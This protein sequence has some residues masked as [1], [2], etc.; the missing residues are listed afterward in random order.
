MKPCGRATSIAL[1]TIGLPFSSKDDNKHT[2][3]A[4]YIIVFRNLNQIQ[5]EELDIS[6][7]QLF[8]NLNIRM[9]GFLNEI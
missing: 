5:S 7:V 4:H 6:Y 2:S 9:L 8:Y 1:K 3:A